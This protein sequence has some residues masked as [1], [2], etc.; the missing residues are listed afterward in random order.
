MMPIGSNTKT[1]NKMARAKTKVVVAPSAKDLVK[2]MERYAESNSKIKVLTGEKEQEVQKLTDQIE[3]INIDFDAK[4]EP[5]IEQMQEDFERLQAYALANQETEFGK[6][7]S[8]DLINGII[9]FRT[10]KPSVAAIKGFTQKAGLENL[11]QLNLTQFVKVTQSIDKNKIINLRTDKE[12]M[13]KVRTAGLEVVQNEQF[14]V[15]VK[16]EVLV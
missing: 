12:L 4:A 7:K 13:E 11:I 15:D 10:D 1:I 3:S 16:E 8:K 9:G 14:F 5:L 6:K 2:I